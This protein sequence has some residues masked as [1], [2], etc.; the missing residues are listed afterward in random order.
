MSFRFSLTRRHV[1]CS[2]WSSTVFVEKYSRRIQ[3]SIE[4]STLQKCIRT[5]PDRY[6]RNYHKH[7][8]AHLF[9][10]LFAIKSANN[11]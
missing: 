4:L 8:F 3:I 11:A 7:R 6:E 2:Q 10:C 1:V 5:N 9:R